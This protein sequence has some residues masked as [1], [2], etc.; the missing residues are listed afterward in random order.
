MED[1]DWR[2][3]AVQD[4]DSRYRPINPKRFNGTV[5]VEWLNVSGG[6]VHGSPP[7]RASVLAT[8]HVSPVVYQLDANGNAIG[9]VRTPQVDAPIAAL[10]SQGNSGGFCLLFGSTVP[11][12]AAHVARLYKSHGQFVSAWARAVRRDRTDGFL[13]TAD[14]AELLRSAAVSQVARPAR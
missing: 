4:A 12:S 10:G 6:V 14:G 13:L 11:Y 2:E 5:V 7:S 9:G 1:H 3:R 8:T